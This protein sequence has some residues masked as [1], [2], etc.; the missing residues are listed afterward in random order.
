MS[1]QRAFLSMSRRDADPDARE[2]TRRRAGLEQRFGTGIDGVVRRNRSG[3]VLFVMQETDEDWHQCLR[4][5]LDCHPA[6]SSLSTSKCI[7]LAP[8]GIARALVFASPPL[9]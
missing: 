2:F 3:S 5:V 4:R 8:G 1:A 6:L 9:A 7:Q